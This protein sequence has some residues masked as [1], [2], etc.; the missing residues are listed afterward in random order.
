MAKT[1]VV[2]VED[3]SIVAKDIQNCLENLGYTVPTI[4]ATGE[5]A[6]QAVEEHKPDL[7]LMDIILKGEMNGI[8]AATFIKDTYNIP[9]IFLTANADD[10]TVNKA[11]LAEP[12]GFII[13]PYR[14]KELQTTIE[15][16]LYKHEK[17]AEIKKERDFYNAIVENREVKDS[18]YVRS[19]YRLNRIKFEDIY[20]IEA[21]KDYVII[22]TAD[23][24]YTTHTTMKEIISILPARDFVRVHRSFIVRLDKIFSIKYPDLVIEG[25]KKVIPIGGLYKKELYSRLNFI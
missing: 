8:D 18:I 1:K 6:I 24:S 10:T 16:V 5:K 2:I 11:K 13:K 22:N 15:M 4:V 23:N 21:L 14:D 25:K 17:V 9:V 7:V 12:Y 3:E 19:D 20:F